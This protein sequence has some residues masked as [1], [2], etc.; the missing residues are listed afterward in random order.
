MRRKLLAVGLVLVLA[1]GVGA[2]RLQRAF[3]SAPSNVLPADYVGPTSCRDCH[4][5]KYSLWRSHPHSRMN[6]DPVA[7]AVRGDFSGQRVTVPGG[8]VVFSTDGGHYFMTL[9]R[10]GKLVRRYVVTRVVGSRFMQFYMGKQ[11]DGPEPR[12]DQL[13]TEESKLPYGYWFRL[14]RWFPENYFDPS[15]GELDAAGKLAYDPFDT[16]RLNPWRWSCMVCH[17]TY[18]YLYR[19][20]NPSRAG[21]PRGDLELDSQKFFP[22]LKGTGL[23]VKREGRVYLQL[24]AEKLTCLGVSCESCHFGGRAHAAGEAEK[25]TF[26]PSSP[27]VNVVPHDGHSDATP[28][29]KNSYTVNSICAQCHCADVPLFPNG[30]GTWNSREALDLEIGACASKIKCTDCHDPHRPGPPEGRDLT[31]QVGACLKCHPKL[32]NAE[33]ASKH[34]GHAASA[35]VSCLDCHMP[36][37]SQGLEETVR[38]HRISSPT[39]AR[40]LAQALPNACNLC[41][42]DRSITWT[43]AA[44]E[45]GWSKKVTPEPSWTSAYGSLDAPMGDTWLASKDHFVRLV[46]S[47]AYAR[48][49]LGKGALGSLV[50]ALEDPVPVNRV[51]AQ[52]AVERISGTPL[53][54]SYDVTAPPEARRA[55]VAALRERLR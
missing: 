43:L 52:L 15:P 28:S 36:R 42:L 4:E 51:F 21:Y 11:V 29:R 44:L 6:S 37:I 45:R 49:P 19:L 10:A 25:P 22:V 33:A 13:Y 27:F 26:G 41:H 16:P 1:G 32:A 23:L 55:Q 38:S 46:A 50:G 39:D 30:A 3:A 31:D 20:A 47:Q 40:M 12:T 17:N 34:S 48:S 35:G 9:E 8:E 24:E 14:A 2:R 5:E 7:N 18:P 54:A 53:G